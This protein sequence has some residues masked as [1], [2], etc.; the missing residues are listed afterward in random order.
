MRGGA[1]RP[2]EV[3]RTTL[4]RD[5]HEDGV[6]TLGLDALPVRRNMGQ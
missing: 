6:D 4:L 3:D 2:C 5:K 1:I